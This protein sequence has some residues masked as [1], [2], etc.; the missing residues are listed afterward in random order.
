[1]PKLTGIF[2][3]KAANNIAWIGLGIMVA[4]KVFS[5]WQT[6]KEKE[7]RQ[8]RLIARIARNDSINQQ[9]IIP[10]LDSIKTTLKRL[11]DKK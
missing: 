11:E 6:D 10:D 1:M 9:K 2:T 8:F 7:Q 5:F 3:N 4:W